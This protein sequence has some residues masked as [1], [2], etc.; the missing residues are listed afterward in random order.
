MT[1]PEAGLVLLYGVAF[2]DGKMAK[3]EI[4][5]IANFVGQNYP[6]NVESK[7]ITTM[8]IDASYEETL[9]Y[10]LVAIAHFAENVSREARLKMLEFV[11]QVILADEEVS[12]QEAETYGLIKAAWGF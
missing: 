3:Q 12:D 10:M 6:G 8:M 4:D 11:Q 7:A 1:A 5:A 9:K 2:S